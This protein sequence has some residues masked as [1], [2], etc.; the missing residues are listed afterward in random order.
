MIYNFVTF[1]SCLLYDKFYKVQDK[2]NIF[3]IP[4]YLYL[5]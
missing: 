2:D 1:L 3:V 4:I 5:N